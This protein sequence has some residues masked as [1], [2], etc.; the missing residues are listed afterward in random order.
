VVLNRVNQKRHQGR[1][2]IQEKNAKKIGAYEVVIITVTK[3]EVGPRKQL[4]VLLK[5]NAP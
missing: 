3:I 4:T 2:T 1:P 5:R